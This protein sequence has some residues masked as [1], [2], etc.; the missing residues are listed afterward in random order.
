MATD[1]GAKSDED[2][3]LPLSALNDLLF[4]ERRCALHRIEQV[5]IDNPHTLEGVHHH[6]RADQ[7]LEESS[8]AG[9]VAHGVLLWSERLRLVG[10]ADIVEF[11]RLPDGGEVPFPVEY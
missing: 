1:V 11:H 2:S 6:R 3:Y 5:W 4:C 10:K 8:K 7:P 9:R